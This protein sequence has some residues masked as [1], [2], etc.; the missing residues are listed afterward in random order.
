[1][2][3]ANNLAHQIF[4]YEA[5]QAQLE[6]I[7]LSARLANVETFVY[8]ADRRFAYALALED[9]FKCPFDVAN[10]HAVYVHS[11][12]EFFECFRAFGIG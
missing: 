9:V 6:H 10:A 12:D 1:M 4:P 2:Q 7:R 3:S 11:F 8:P 5:R